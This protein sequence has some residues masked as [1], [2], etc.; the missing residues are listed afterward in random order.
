MRSR[1][2]IAAALCASLASASPLLQLAQPRVDPSRMSVVEGGY[3][4]PIYYTKPGT[5]GYSIMW[6]VRWECPFF[7]ASQT[8]AIKPALFFQA[9]QSVEPARATADGGPKLKSFYKSDAIELDDNA[10]WGIA[11]IIPQQS[12]FFPGNDRRYAICCN[13]TSD[14]DITLTVGGTEKF[15]PSTTNTLN[16]FNIE[17]YDG[18]RS[19]AITAADKNAKIKVAFAVNPIKQFFN[20][21]HSQPDYAENINATN[22]FVFAALRCKLGEDGVQRNQFTLIT[23]E[24]NSVQNERYQEFDLGYTEYPGDNMV[25]MQQHTMWGQID[26]ASD[27]SKRRVEWY[28]LKYVDDYITDEQMWRI[29]DVDRQHI[30]ARGLTNALPFVR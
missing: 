7:D 3:R 18:D 13:I 6:W 11:N 5:T 17:V 25:V 24:G 30:Y 15:V 4:L 28:G 21:A 29:Y 2:I 22:R 14:T 1:L 10:S 27:G 23:L 26:V 9:M 20:Q 8:G 12:V 19:I 16:I